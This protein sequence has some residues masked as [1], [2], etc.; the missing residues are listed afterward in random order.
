MK[1]KLL[2]KLRKQIGIYTD[3]DDE[4]NKI[5]SVRDRSMWSNYEGN[6][7]FLGSFKTLEEAKVKRR[8]AIL[9]EARRYF[10]QK[11]IV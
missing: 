8:K 5:F 11:R 7:Y 3:L 9:I 6:F 1:V 10:E 2:K 4:G